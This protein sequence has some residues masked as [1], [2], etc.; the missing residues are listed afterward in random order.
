MIDASDK[1]PYIEV[2]LLPGGIDLPGTVE[3]LERQLI[4]KAMEVA[5]GNKARAAELLGLK[6]TTLLAK[7]TRMGLIEAPAAPESDL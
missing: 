3:T 6:R 4:D 7:M 5:R 1:I 2:I